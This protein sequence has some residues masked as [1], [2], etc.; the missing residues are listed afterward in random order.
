[1]KAEYMH[2]TVATGGPV[3]SKVL[4]HCSCCRVFF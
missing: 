2:I 3:E 4:T 1:L